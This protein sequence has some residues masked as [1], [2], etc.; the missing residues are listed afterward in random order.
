MWRDEA[1]L[2]DML[3]AARKAEEFLGAEAL[4]RF[5]DDELRQSAVVRQLEIVGEAASKISS[6][7]VA[8]HPEIPWAEITGMRHRLIHDYRHVDVERVWYTVTERVPEL[9]VLLEPLIPPE[10]DSA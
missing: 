4:T 8:E 3:I 2:L 7:F 10:E 6:E 1:Y 9:I 5:A